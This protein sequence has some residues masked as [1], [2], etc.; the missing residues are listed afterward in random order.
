[1]SSGIRSKL[2]TAERISQSG[3]VQVRYKEI[4]SD[5]RQDSQTIGNMVAVQKPW[6][7]LLFLAVCVLVCLG[8]LVDAY[9]P[10]PTYPG[11]NASPE[12][13]AKYYFELRHYINMITRQRFGKRDNLEAL[14]DSPFDES[15]DHIGKSRYD[16]SL[17]W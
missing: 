11:I 6:T 12:K 3:Q 14:S 4:F 15:R 17:M 1:M 16:D 9:P 2:R 5:R 13:L 7:N 10:K 8:T